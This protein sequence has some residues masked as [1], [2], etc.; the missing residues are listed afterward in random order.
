MKPEKPVVIR[1]ILADNLWMV[2]V[3]KE[4]ET[5]LQKSFGKHYSHTTITTAGHDSWDAVIVTPCLKQSISLPDGV[6]TLKK[7]EEQWWASR[8]IEK[9]RHKIFLGLKWDG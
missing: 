7:F 9:G 3:L 1:R 6:A 4:L 8:R 5:Q 2:P